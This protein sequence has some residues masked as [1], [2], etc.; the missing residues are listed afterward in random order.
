MC[1]FRMETT[2]IGSIGHCVLY[3]VVASVAVL[4]PDSDRLS[5]SS[6]V[7]DL[8]LFA[9]RLPV[10]GFYP[11]IIFRDYTLKE[12]ITNGLRVIVD[13]STEDQI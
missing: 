1:P 8:G 10:T 6:E 13:Y 2:F 9:L 7:E 4:T 11:K 5:I 12:L 3:S